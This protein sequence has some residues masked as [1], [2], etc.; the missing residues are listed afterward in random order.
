MPGYG[1]SNNSAPLMLGS[2]L[3]IESDGT[4]S[5]SADGDDI[6]GISDEDGVA[7]PIHVYPNTTTGVGVVVT[8]N[9]AEPATLAGWIDLNNDGQFAVSERVT[10]AIPANSGQTTQTLTFPAGTPTADSFARFRLFGGAVADPQ[11][12][13]NAAGGEVEDSRALVGVYEV[14]KTASPTGRLLPG[15][16]VTYSITVTATGGAPLTNAATFSDDLTNV[17]DDAVYNNDASA[18]SG[19]ISYTSPNLQW[20]GVLAP[21]Q[22][23]TVTYSVTV[24]E[25]GDH[26]MIN[27]VIGGQCPA[28][29]ITDP[30][31]PDFIAAC[32]T[33]TLV[34]DPSADLTVAKSHTG[35]PVAGTNV[36][37]RLDV[38]NNGPFSTANYT[39]TDLLDPSVSFVSS[40][41]GCIANGQTVTCTGGSLASGQTTTLTFIV[42][43][44]PTHNGSVIENRATVSGPLPDPQPGNNISEDLFDPSAEADVSIIKERSGSFI[45]GAT[46]TYNLT[47]TNN[48]PSA[49]SGVTVTDQLPD[50]LTPISVAAPGGWQCVFVA[51]GISCLNEDTMMPG[52]VDVLSFSVNVPSNMTGETE[53]T[54]RVTATTFDP[55]TSNNISVAAATIETEAD[56]A[57]TKELEG[58]LIAGENAIY[59]LTV[60]NNGPSNALEPVVTDE[61]PSALR[62]IE[63]TNDGWLCNATEQTVSCQGGSIVNGAS[64][65]I[66]MRVGV[67]PDA[68]GQI[69]NGATVISATPDPVP[70][71]NSAAA[72]AR[73]Q[74]DTLANSGM[75]FRV[76]AIAA[77]VIIVGTIMTSGLYLRQ[78]HRGR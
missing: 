32:S 29:A 72:T 60:T 5:A 36:E 63:A 51:N 70:S 41:S 55:N 21:G 39:V 54:A 18:T 50:P 75:D 33:L 2:K 23:S 9:T 73:V 65:V 10:V 62:Y 27:A 59:R 6:G 13:G 52:E 66:E 26:Q 53:N 61:L 14:V 45:A 25:S 64:N 11:P 78:Y 38:T 24:G 40:G 47:V 77:I 43:V 30:S 16:V 8:N 58:A 48:G 19:A 20:Q 42:M 34:E 74:D 57:I 22:T 56:L 71:N 46:A 67:K 76:V 4:P 3:D 28:P 17:L 7:L 15:Q 69:V 37:Y 1:T 31:H 44:S 68:S 35:S 49:A 12:N